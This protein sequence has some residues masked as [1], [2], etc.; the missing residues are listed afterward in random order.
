[1]DYRKKG[2]TLIELLVVIAIIA[3]LLSILLPALGR[4]RSQARTIACQGLIRQ[5]AMGHIGYSIET[6]YILPISV[7]DPIMR[8]WYTF[9]AY[10]NYMGLPDLTEEYKTR[11]IE[12]QE[13]KPSYPPDFICPSASYA[14][15]HPEDGLYPM[16]RSYGMNTHIYYRPMG[17]QNLVQVYFEQKPPNFTA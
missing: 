11:R 1:M 7:N 4:A 6:N 9:D 16:D 13:Y 12:L 10:R 15:N 3:L 5:L 2:F 8:P 14:L 17:F